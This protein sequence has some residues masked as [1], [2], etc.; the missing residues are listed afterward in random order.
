MLTDTLAF[1]LE[2]A[3]ALVEFVETFLGARFAEAVS[4]V[5]ESGLEAFAETLIDTLFF[6]LALLGIAVE[7]D[8]FVVRIINALNMHRSPAGGF[9]GDSRFSFE[10]PG[11]FAANHPIAVA[12]FAQPAQI[13]LG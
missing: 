8:L 2:S 3:D 4:D 5:L 11:P 12:V 7:P 10:L 1:F 13:G 6:L 9:D